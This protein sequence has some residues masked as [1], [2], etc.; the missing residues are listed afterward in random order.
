MPTVTAEEFARIRLLLLDVD[1]VLTDGRVVYSDAGH[2]IKSFHVRDGSG[3]KYWR[4]SGGR[5]AILSGRSSAAVTRRAAELG[6]EPVVQGVDEKLPAFRRILN[7]LGMQADQVCAIGDDLPDLPVLRQCGL[8]VA[9]A[10]AAPEVRQLARFVTSTPGGHGAVREAIEWLMRGQGKWD[11]VVDG[12][13]Q[14]SR[15]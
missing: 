7:E 15:E 10:D 11:A 14:S 8:P 9:V 5:T 3:L 4:Q 2:E 1:G 12:L 13:R 6:I